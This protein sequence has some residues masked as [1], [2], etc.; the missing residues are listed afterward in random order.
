M[1]ERSEEI[2][3]DIIHSAIFLLHFISY[4]AVLALKSLFDTKLIFETMLKKFSSLIMC[5]VYIQKTLQ[6]EEK[7]TFTAFSET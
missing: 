2:L 3:R 6:I 7:N 1:A 4:H 5:L